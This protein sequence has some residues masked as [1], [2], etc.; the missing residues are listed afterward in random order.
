V[1]VCPTCHALLVEVQAGADADHQFICGCTRTT[2]LYR[3]NG[4]LERRVQASARVER[5]DGR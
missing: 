5:S 1:I 4:D 3:G 2:W